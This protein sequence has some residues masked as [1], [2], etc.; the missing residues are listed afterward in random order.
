MSFDVFAIQGNGEWSDQNGSGA[1]DNLGLGPAEH[2]VEESDQPIDGGCRRPRSSVSS[3]RARKSASKGTSG[4]PARNGK[5]RA[6]KHDRGGYD[7]TVQVDY[8]EPAKFGASESSPLVA[9]E[10]E[11]GQQTPQ[12]ISR[13]ALYALSVVRQ[14]VDQ[15]SSGKD[16]QKTLGKTT[17]HY[18]TL[19]V[20][21]ANTTTATYP[22]TVLSKDE[23]EWVTFL[24]SI[25]Q[26]HELKE[27][28]EAMDAMVD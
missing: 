13:Q 21:R 4:K 19:A 22:L 23:Q 14:Q 7:C 18:L 25:A 6:P 12:D 20:S 9:P 5:G 26:P 17:L 8:S 28:H 2:G 24:R 11:A 27:Y 10:S 1:V 16:D 15:Q 3:R